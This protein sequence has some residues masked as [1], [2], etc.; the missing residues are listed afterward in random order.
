MI[1]YAEVLL[2]NGKTDYVAKNLWTGNDN[3]NHG[4]PI[5]YDLDY[6]VDNWSGP[7][8]DLWEE[9]RVNDLFWNRI[10]TRKALLA[11]AAFAKA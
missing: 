11:G 5:K 3:D 7:T 10:T 1:M 8:C 9:I 2:K 6:V 4:G